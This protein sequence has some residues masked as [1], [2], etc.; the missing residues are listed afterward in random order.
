MGYS[1]WDQKELDLT[2]QPNTY[3]HNLPNVPKLTVRGFAPN[4]IMQSP[5]S[6]PLCSAEMNV[7]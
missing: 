6:G 3:T 1:S 4:C 5:Y 2:E 7:F